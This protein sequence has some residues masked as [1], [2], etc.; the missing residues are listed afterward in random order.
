MAFGA[1][2]DGDDDHDAADAAVRDER[3]DAVDDPAV[4][5]THGRRPHA[6]GVAAGAGFGQPPRAR[7][8]RRCTSRG[9][10]CCFCASLPNMRDVRGAQTV[11]RG[12]RERDRRTDARQ[13]LDADAVVDRRQRGAAVLLGE[14]DA[15]SSPSAASF[16]SRSIGKLLRL[17]PLHDVRANLGFRELAD[18]PAQQLLLFGQ[19]GSPLTVECITRHGAHGS[20]SRFGG[21]RSSAILRHVQIAPGGSS[22]SSRCSRSR[23]P[24]RPT[25]PRSSAPIPRRSIAST[26]VSASAPGS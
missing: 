20:R 18:R 26:R 9:R 4:A 23:L 10:Y 19:A 11:V 25:S 21:A 14:L 15:R 1:I 16:G 22:L 12:D 8:R 24:P 2:G 7:A 3:L 5:L 17:V 6:G 13:L